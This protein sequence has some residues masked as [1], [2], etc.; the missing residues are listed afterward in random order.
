MWLVVALS[1]CLSYEDG[2][3]QRGGLNCQL[4]EA[5]GELDTYGFDDVDACTASA[6]SQPY[7]AADC[8]D[9]DA[10]EMR[11]CIAAYEDAVAAKDCEA[12]FTD[13]CAVCE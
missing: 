10:G 1:G 11:R 6:E 5:C 9:Y 13:V 3:A 12:D 7:D 2:Q 4:L 8:K